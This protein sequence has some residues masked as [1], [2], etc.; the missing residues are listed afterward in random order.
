MYLGYVRS[1][2][3]QHLALQS[4]CS[5]SQ[6]QKLDKVQNEAVKFISGGMKSSPISACEIDS[7]I[8]PLSF[9]REAS[10]VEM[11]ERFRRNDIENPNRKIIDKWTPSETIKQE[12]ILKVEK[13]LQE[14]HHMPTNREC[15][16]YFSK[17]L[18][19]N[20]DILAP[21]INL[22]LIE[23][24]S[25]AKTD[26]VELYQIGIKTIMSY[27]DNLHQVYTDGSAFKGTINAG[28]GA[29]IEFKDKTCN[30]LSE[31]C[32]TLCG[33]YEAEIFGLKHALQNLKETFEN[34]PQKKGDCV[35][36]S[37]SLSVLT[38]L[39]EQNYT[40]KAIRDLAVQISSF[41]RTFDLNLILQWIPSHCG[42][43]GNERADYLAKKGAAKTQPDKPVSQATVKQII[44]SNNK[45][46]WYNKWAQ[47]D[48]GRVMFHHM[49]QPN[50]SDPINSL[51]RKDQVVIFPLRTNHIQ[52][53][54]HLNRILKD[55]QPAC[56][57]CGYREETVHH[58]LFEC[59]PLQDI[60]SH[61]L[62]PNPNRENTLYAP[63]LQLK[64]TSRYYHEANHRR[65]RV[66][67]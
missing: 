39:N 4:I 1:V 32:G 50:K 56:P 33:N 43:P 51:E 46:E 19:P 17:D 18:P 48:K 63:L 7:I 41:I 54:A 14:K 8:E 10:V 59:P 37:D 66:Q 15:N 35:I 22:C 36:F 55:H 13:R 3:E 27:P 34:Q 9:R 31:P 26:P 67:D 45:I 23:E 40:T 53:N 25:K 57:L 11:A 60:R 49:P 20:E 21:Q 28:C 24:V 65:T 12:S 64:N 2:L 38:I 42:I 29:R 44:K 16:A 30:E 61:F 52:L 47:N 62:P 58:F 5:T 6:Q